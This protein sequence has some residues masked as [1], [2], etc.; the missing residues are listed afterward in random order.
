MFWVILSFVLIYVLIFILHNRREQANR[1]LV[2][3]LFK[4]YVQEVLQWSKKG[5]KDKASANIAK[6]YLMALKDYMRAFHIY[7]DNIKVLIG[8]DIHELEKRV[9][10]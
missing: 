8:I 5:M 1:E 6:G 7:P 9:N 2:I 4:R 3:S 10:V